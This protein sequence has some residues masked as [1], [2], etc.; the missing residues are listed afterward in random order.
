MIV[1]MASALSKLARIAR[2]I[3]SRPDVIEQAR[4]ENATWEQIAEALD[5]SR[6]GV[7][8]LYNTRYS[9]RS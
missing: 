4:Q 8:K 5:M 1:D 2:D 7:I 9:D 3:E 6:A